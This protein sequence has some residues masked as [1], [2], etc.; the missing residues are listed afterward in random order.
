MKPI[1]PGR[2]DRSTDKCFLRRYLKERGVPLATCQVQFS[3]LSYGSLQKEVLATCEDL[4]ITVISYSPLALGLLTNKYSRD[5]PP[6]GLR[7]FAL[8]KVLERMDPLRRELAAV[9]EDCKASP[10]QVAITWCCSKNTVPIPGAKNLDQAMSNRGA[11]DV[12]LSEQHC[13]ALEASA[14][15]CSDSMVQNI[16]QSA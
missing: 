9:A 7:K 13:Q 1:R 10:A 11:L 15:L 3:L 14:A 5:R 12:R 16:F 4:G 6:P 2:V 8:R